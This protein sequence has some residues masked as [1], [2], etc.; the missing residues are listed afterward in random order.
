M[1]HINNTKLQLSVD[2]TVRSRSKNY[3]ENSSCPVK[4]ETN[5]C[6]NDVY[7]VYSTEF[8]DGL[9]SKDEFLILA[10]GKVAF[11][12]LMRNVDKR[13]KNLL[14]VCYLID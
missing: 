9:Y 4:F 6:W 5:S 13:K 2:I 11:F 8:L 1:L 12:D 7:K 10:R 3:L 14:I